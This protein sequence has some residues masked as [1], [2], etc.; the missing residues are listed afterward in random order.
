MNFHGHLEV[1][2]SD[3]PRPTHALIHTHGL[4]V[5]RTRYCMEMGEM[6]IR[7]CQKGRPRISRDIKEAACMRVSLVFQTSITI[8]A[9]SIVMLR[10]RRRRTSSSEKE[11]K[12]GTLSADFADESA[13]KKVVARS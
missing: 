12:C 5:V 10:C 13:T 11:K 8:H 9:H 1:L 7:A 2:P 3:S 6:P 4:T